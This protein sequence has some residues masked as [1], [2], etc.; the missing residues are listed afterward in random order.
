MIQTPI[1]K[2]HSKNK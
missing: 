2:R 1:F